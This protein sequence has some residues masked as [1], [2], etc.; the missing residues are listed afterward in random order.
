MLKKCVR[1]CYNILP[2]DKYPHHLI[3]KMVCTQNFWLNAFPHVDGISQMMSPKE[4]ITGFKVNFLQ[5]C[6]LEFGDY[7][8]TDEEHMNDIRSCMIGA[9][10]LRPTRNSQGGYYFFSLMMGCVIACQ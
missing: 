7:V 8:Q 9:L 5:H 10:L 2:F 6:K 1:A 3:I 4:I